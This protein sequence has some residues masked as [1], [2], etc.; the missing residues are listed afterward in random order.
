MGSPV[1]L[2]LAHCFMEW[3]EQKAIAT[4]PTD[5]KPKLWK[6]YLDDILEIIKRGKV[7]ALTGHLNGIDKTNSIKFTHEPEKNGRSR[8]WTLL[9][10]GGRTDPSNYWFTRKP[11]TQTSTCRFNRIIRFSINLLSYGRYTERSERP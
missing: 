5:C 2:I 3:L 1:S 11:H 6:R 4:A 10:P 9:S 7:E 8:F